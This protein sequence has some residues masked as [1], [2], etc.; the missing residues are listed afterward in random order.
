[1]AGGLSCEDV[2]RVA[3][4]ARLALTAEEVELYRIQLDQILVHAQQLCD[5]PAP[6]VPAGAGSITTGTAERPDEPR[7]SMPATVALANAPD[8]ACG[9]ALFRAPRVFSE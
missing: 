4:L 3:T 2:E 6:S 5:Y 7:P 8:R 1:M 9:T